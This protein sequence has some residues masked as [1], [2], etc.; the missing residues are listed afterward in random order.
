MDRQPPPDLTRRA[1]AEA[2]GSAFLLAAVVGSGIMA[3][4]LAGGNVGLAL[5]ANSIATGAALIALIL[6]LAP[7]SGAHMNPAVT[8]VEAAGGA[9]PW[10][11]VPAYL[12][13]QVLGAL[14]GVAVANMMFALPPILPARQ[15]RTG[16]DQWLSEV[17][18]TFGLVMVIRGSAHLGIP[19]VAVAVGSYITAAYWFTGSTSFANPAVTLA[20]TASDT[21]AGI[22]AIDAPAFIVCQAVGAA[23]AAATF[24][25]LLPAPARHA[26]STATP[27]EPS[28]TVEEPT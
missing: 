18:A 20:R 1:A 2:L 13:A 17:V 10:R 19:R 26:A 23:A 11:E 24:R 7:I 25:W 28:P 27:R 21:F 14:G 15:A 12:V 3:S 16:I 22:R 6:A 9:L 4:R 8:L 5:L